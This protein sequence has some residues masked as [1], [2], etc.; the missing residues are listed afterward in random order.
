MYW[1]LYY[2]FIGSFGLSFGSFINSWVWRVRENLDI[3]RTRSVCPKC[4][5]QIAWYDN[6]PLISF[7]ILR[8]KCRHCR[9][10]ISWQYPAVEVFVALFFL[11][12]AV[13]HNFGLF[14]PQLTIALIRDLII[15]VLLTFIFLYDLKYGEILDRVTILPGVILVFLS[16][17]FPSHTWQSLLLGVL[18]GAGFFLI[19]Y[20]ISRGAWIG[21][22]DIRLGFFMGAILGWPN[23]LVAF[24]IAYMLGAIN[25]LILIALKK[26]TMKSKTAFGAYLAVGTLV[27]MFFANNIINWYWGFL[28]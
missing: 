10:K 20:I 25:S 18:F 14:L 3:S 15:I 28:S 21:G 9:D 2:F 23:I 12:A 8:A 22:G 26:K 6:I 27:S 1:V 16:L 17:V 4:L 13:W 24:F 11:F 7:F 5:R 19:L